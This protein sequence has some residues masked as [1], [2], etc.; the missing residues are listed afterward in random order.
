M[1]DFIHLVCSNCGAVNRVPANRAG[2]NPN[3]GKCRQKVL[4]DQP[5]EL[6]SSTFDRFIVR[7]D[8]PVVVD[9]W[10]AWCGP[11]KAMAPAFAETAKQLRSSV[12]FAKLDTEAEQSVAA[13]FGIRSIPTLILFHRGKEKARQAGAMGAA[14]IERWLSSASQ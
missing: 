14:D 13:K 4:S 11:C 10:A 3:C 7:N 12:R 2:D 1:S 6:R 8:L 9:F 5:I